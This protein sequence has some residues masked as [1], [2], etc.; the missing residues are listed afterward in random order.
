MESTIKRSLVSVQTGDVSAKEGYRKIKDSV[1]NYNRA[2]RVKPGYASK[3]KQ[4]FRSVK[5]ILLGL[6]VGVIPLYKAE[7]QIMSRL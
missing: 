7:Q 1:E 4:V 5:S 6:Q 3:S 2:I